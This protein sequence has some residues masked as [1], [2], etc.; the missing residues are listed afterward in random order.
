MTATPLRQPLGFDLRLPPESL[1]SSMWPL[2]RREQ[3]LLNPAI[4]F[5]LSVDARVWPSA[6]APSA[7]TT[8]VGGPLDAAVPTLLRGM[9]ELIDAFSHRTL[10]ASATPIAIA[11]VDER[12]LAADRSIWLASMLEGPT[13]PDWPHGW[14]RLGYDVVSAEF[15]SGLANCGYEPEVIP[16]LRA[17]WAPKL[18]EVGLF[19]LHADAVAFRQLSDLR[20]PEHQPFLV[21]ELVRRPSDLRQS[22]VHRVG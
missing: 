18:N 14:R 4:D 13:R 15:V 1:A 10:V 21:F 3:Y 9:S 22:G 19:A 17:E 7:P 6:L 11:L 16:R 20:V 2:E 12:P 8:G 5:P